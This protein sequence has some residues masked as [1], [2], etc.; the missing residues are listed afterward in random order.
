MLLCKEVV[1]RVASGDALATYD[2]RRSVHAEIGEELL[3]ETVERLRD[4]ALRDGNRRDFELIDKVEAH[5]Q[6]CK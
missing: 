2:D 5:L 6:G 3:M 4:Y 1:E